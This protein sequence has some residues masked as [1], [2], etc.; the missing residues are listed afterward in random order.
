M[1]KGFQLW[2]VIAIVAIH[3]GGWH[4]FMSSS[5]SRIGRH[6]VSIL[7]L[8]QRASPES[9]IGAIRFQGNPLIEGMPTEA[10]STTTRLRAERIDEARG[11]R[12]RSGNR[13]LQMCDSSI[14]SAGYNASCALNDASGQVFFALMR[15]DN[16]ASLG[17]R[18]KLSTTPRTLE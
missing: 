11:A 6:L 14:V 12:W 16:C 3:D 10:L 8:C 5:C 2:H 4:F 1:V 15:V 9:Q 18:A 7:I 13:S 17:V